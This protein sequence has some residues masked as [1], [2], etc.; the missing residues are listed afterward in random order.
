MDIN[1]KSP[2]DIDLELVDPTMYKECIGFLMYRVN[3]RLDIYAMQERAQ[4]IL[5]CNLDKYTG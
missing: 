5:W 1:N 4:V 2:N 3:T